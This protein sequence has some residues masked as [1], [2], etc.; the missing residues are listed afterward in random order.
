MGCA[1]SAATGTTQPIPAG[2][3]TDSGQESGS[4]GRGW[5]IAGFVFLALAVIGA[6]ALLIVR[7]LRGQELFSFR[8]RGRKGRR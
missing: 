8:F 2:S 5:L 7:V 6:G 4:G 3:Q 1:L